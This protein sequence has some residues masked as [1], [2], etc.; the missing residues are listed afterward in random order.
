MVIVQKI[1]F[2]LKIYID[3]TDKKRIIVSIDYLTQLY[4]LADNA[5]YEAKKKDE[6]KLL[7]IKLRRN[8]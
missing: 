5:L 8:F 7:S 6:I 4:R 1:L 2:F 3:I